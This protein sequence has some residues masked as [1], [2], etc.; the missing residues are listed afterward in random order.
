MAS[1]WN[2]EHGCLELG[3]AERQFPVE[4]ARDV[5]DMP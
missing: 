4:V 2:L 3:A 1:R 5:A